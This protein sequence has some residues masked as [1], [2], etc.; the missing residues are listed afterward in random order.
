MTR[1]KRAAKNEALF[2]D[3][4]ERI[5]ALSLTQLDE[6]SDVLCECCDPNCMETIQ[7]TFGEYNDVRAEGTR[8]AI[9]PGHEDR[10]VERVLERRERFFVV[11]KTD[12]EAADESRRRDPRS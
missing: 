12:P 9:V 4:N 7:L 5:K 8:F 11:E 2:R 10:S 3:V 6:R 1:G